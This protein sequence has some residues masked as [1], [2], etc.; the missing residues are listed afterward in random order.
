MTQT[1]TKKQPQ[2]H[3]RVK[4]PDE[5]SNPGIKWERWLLACSFAL[6]ALSCVTLLA[7]RSIATER[8][9]V[10]FAGI[11]RDTPIT[12]GR[13]TLTVSDIRHKPAT[14]RFAAP[15]G[16]EYVLLTLTVR[17]NSEKPLDVFPSSDT[18]IKTASGNVSYLTPYDLVRPF[19]SGTVLPGESTVGEL[20][21]LVPK[22]STYKF[23][24][25]ASW[26]GG[27]VPFMIQST[28]NHKRDT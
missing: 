1:F 22:Y 14:K 26:S 2:V 5:A 7:A 10:P 4:K 9:R 12:T 15:D 28:N 3:S 27:A 21:F 6:L 23:Y 18:Y 16:Y 17:N 8:V 11:R 20:S 24:V 19:H 25:E 13:T